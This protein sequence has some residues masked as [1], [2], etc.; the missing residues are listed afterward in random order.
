VIDLALGARKANCFRVAIRSKAPSTLTF[1]FTNGG[2]IEVAQRMAGH[3]NVKTGL[4]DRRNDGMGVGGGRARRLGF[5][6]YAP[7]ERPRS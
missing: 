6:W 3:S 4:C 2:H 5:E 1:N 7:D